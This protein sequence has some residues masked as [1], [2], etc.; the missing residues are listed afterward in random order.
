MKVQS[1]LVSG[2][3]ALG[4]AAVAGAQEIKLTVPGA[5]AEPAKA[6]VTSA[7]APAAIQAPAPVPTFTEPQVIES[8]G[9]AIAQQVQLDSLKLS[10]EQL[11]NFFKG[12]APDRNRPRNEEGRQDPCHRS[13][14]SGSRL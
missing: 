6:P 13:D 9:W 10:T 8:L 7:A 5:P 4:F 11:E 3:F 2:L 12:I 14:S 1:A